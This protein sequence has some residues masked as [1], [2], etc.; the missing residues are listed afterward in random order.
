MVFQPAFLDQQRQKQKEQKEQKQISADHG[1]DAQKIGVE[2]G[3]EKKAQEIAVAE[4]VIITPAGIT[5][6]GS[7]IDSSTSASE[8]QS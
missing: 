6:D 4:D 7:K 8:S 3:V 1:L 5:H 2:K